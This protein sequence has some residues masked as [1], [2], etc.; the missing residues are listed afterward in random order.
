MKKKILDIFSR[1]E[2][3]KKDLYTCIHIRIHVK[4]D[5]CFG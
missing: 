4:I 5:Q 1:R 2:D 3:S